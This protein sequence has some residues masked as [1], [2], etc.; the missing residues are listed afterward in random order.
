MVLLVIVVIVTLL[1]VVVILFPLD[2]PRDPFSQAPRA[3][4]PPHHEVTHLILAFVILA[5]RYFHLYSLILQMLP[6]KQK[7]FSLTC[8]T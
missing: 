4:T 3:A 2:L 1:V 8:G 6:L 7:P 5:T